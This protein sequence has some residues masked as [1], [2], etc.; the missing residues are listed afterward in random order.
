MKNLVGKIKTLV[1]VNSC[2]I[3]Q[4]VV[5]LSRIVRYEWH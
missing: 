2:G 4:V 3:K 5:V 1:V